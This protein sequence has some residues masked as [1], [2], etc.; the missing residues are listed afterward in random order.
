MNEESGRSNEQV[1][2]FKRDEFMRYLDFQIRAW[3]TDGIHGQVIAHSTPAGDMREP[4]TVRSYL[5]FYE[6]YRRIIERVGVSGPSDRE[7]FFRLGHKLW[8]IIFPPPVLSLLNES[9]DRIGPENGLRI[10]LCFDDYLADLPWEFLCDPS[11]PDSF[12]SFLVLNPRISLVRAA[13]RPSFEQQQTRRRQ[14]LVFVGVKGPDGQG[15][16]IKIG[17]LG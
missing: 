1:P 6:D 5:H 13:P 14:R 3:Q 4:I 16:R 11:I 8:G 12:S 17:E 9:L 15:H 7:S 10:R 2:I